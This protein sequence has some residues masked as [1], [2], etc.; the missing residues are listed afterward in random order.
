MQ[1]ICAGKFS[2]SLIWLSR[3]K[4]DLNRLSS[5]W[6]SQIDPIGDNSLVVDERLTANDKISPS[7]ALVD[8]DKLSKDAVYLHTN[9]VVLRTYQ[10]TNMEAFLEITRKYDKVSNR[11]VMLHFV[12]AAF[13][14]HFSSFLLNYVVSCIAMTLYKTF[15]SNS[16]NSMCLMNV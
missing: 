15:Q 8:V 7:A 2:E 14:Y 16:R 12:E 4:D 6:S 3:F 5:S 10:M 13:Y 11:C 1:C 9:L